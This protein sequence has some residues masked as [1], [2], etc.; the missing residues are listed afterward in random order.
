MVR[1]DF[2]FRLGYSPDGLVGDDGLI[3]I[4]S[5][6]QKKHLATMLADEVPLENM[7]QIQCGLLVSGR[8]WCDYVSYCGG[9]PLYVKRVLPD[10]KWHDAILEAVKTFEETVAQ[11]IDNFELAAAGRPLTDRIDHYAEMDLF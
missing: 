6:R 2:G 9:M 1:D 3:E 7:A 10:K 8:A 4:K 5:R 11:M